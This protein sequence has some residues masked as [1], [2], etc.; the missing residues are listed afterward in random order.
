[1]RKAA[2]K[3]DHTLFIA[4]SVEQCDINWFSVICIRCSVITHSKKEIE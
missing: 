4:F 1:M 2:P 3:K